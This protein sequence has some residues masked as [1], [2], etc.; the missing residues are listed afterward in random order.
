MRNADCFL[1]SHGSGGTLSHR[2]L[3]ELVFPALRNPYLKDDDSAVIGL[4]GQNAFTTDS[5]VVKPLF[6][7]GGDIG[8]LAVCGTVNDLA[9]MAARPLYLTAACIVEEGFAMADFRKV[10]A[11][12]KKACDE[13]KTAIV[14][15]D[16]KVVEKG[17]CDGMFITTSGIGAILAGTACRGSAAK[18]GDDIVINGYI[19]DHG[20][21]V[22]AS[23]DD[24]GLRTAIRSDCCPLNGL[25][26]T[27]VK[28][29]AGIR[30]MRDPTRGG[31]ATTLNEI[32]RSSRVGMEIDERLLPVRPA[33]R[34]LSEI[35]GIDP[36]Y[37]ANEGKL[38][39][40]C[41]SRD[42]SRLLRAMRRHRYGR[43]SRVIGKVTGGREPVVLLRTSIGSVR[44]LDMLTGEQLPRI[45]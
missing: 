5:F 13:A 27:M 10:L 23:R 4:D 24:Y 12:M 42:T 40:F 22:M 28:S 3:E 32:A 26:E 15:G 29:G 19:G 17:A 11:S 9:M 39:A 44:I 30:A 38:L 33:V 37:L 6:F 2:L 7:P 8:R 36:L 21:A 25:V 45:C 20:A 16:L 31:V 41:P 14:G 35:L 1:L 43:D 18:A 34:G